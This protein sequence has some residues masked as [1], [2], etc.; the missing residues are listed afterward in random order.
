MVDVMMTVIPSV[1][2]YALLSL[3]YI[4]R[5]LRLVVKAVSPVGPWVHLIMG[6]YL[7]RA[8]EKA[9]LASSARGTM[10]REQRLSYTGGSS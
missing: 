5:S 2:I 8:K 7:T 4:C 1:V 9:S 6:L 10:G 3:R